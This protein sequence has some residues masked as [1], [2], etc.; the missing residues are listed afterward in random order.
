MP[1]RQQDP[2]GSNG[3]ATR[4]VGPFLR[5]A[6]GKRQLRKTLLTFLP[7]DIRQRTYREPFLGGGSLFFAIR[8]RSAVLSDANEHLIR[9]YEFVR[10]Q[11][12][13][14]ARYLQW[15]SSKDSETYYYRVRDKYNA[16][17]FSAA[18]AA[19]FIYLNKTCF[20]GIFRVNTEGRF[21]VPYGHKNSPAIP[22]EN[23]LNNIATVLIKASLQAATFE[24]A[25]AGASG[26][27]FIYLDPPYPPLN[28]TAY[29][30]HYTCGRFSEQDQAKL[31][32]QVHELNRRGCL[33]MISNADT[34]LIRRLYRNYELVSLPVIRFLTCKSVRHK[35]KELVITNY[36]RPK[37]KEQ[38][39]CA[40]HD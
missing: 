12:A 17:S 36:H 35:V 27:D 37:A 25:L 20:N 28:G 39:A 24:R 33:L 14:V 16:S 11:P 8:P 1:D 5:W 26:G 23:E 15:H 6:G 32:T 19:R 34:P 7:T 18:Q 2:H 9:C 38:L 40:Y 29:F 22:D 13:L 30:T 21:N 31:A 10:D 3:N 4:T